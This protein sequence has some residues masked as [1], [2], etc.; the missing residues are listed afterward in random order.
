LNGKESDVKVVEVLVKERRLNK[1]ILADF[2]VRKNIWEY[3]R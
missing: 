1:R 2:W 3:N